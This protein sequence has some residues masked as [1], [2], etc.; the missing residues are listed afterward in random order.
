MS[1]LRKLLRLSLADWATIAM[2]YLWLFRVRRQVGR[3]K[4]RDLLKTRPES[5][6]PQAQSSTSSNDEW[7]ARR[8]RAINIA[9]RYPFMWAK[10]LPRSIALREWLARDGFY[11][12]LHIG[13]RREGNSI[14]AHAWLEKG[15][16]V[17]N[18]AK[19]VTAY[20]TPLTSNRY[21]GL[22]NV[23]EAHLEWTR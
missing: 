20:F 3:L 17:V 15:G 12:D 2:A 18:D 8:V 19:E 6:R 21:Q 5:A 4:G 23:S 7:I 22:E 14:Q 16:N 13:V 1:Y 9:A 10:C 11:A